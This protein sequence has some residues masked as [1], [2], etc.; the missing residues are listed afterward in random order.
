MTRTVNCAS[1]SSKSS[2]CPLSQTLSIM[3]STYKCTFCT[4]CTH[5][6]TACPIFGLTKNCTFLISGEKF[7]RLS[8]FC[9][10]CSTRYKILYDR[11]DT[12]FVCAYK[13]LNSVEIFLMYR[14]QFSSLTFAKGPFTST[15]IV[16]HPAEY[17]LV[18]QRNEKTKKS[19]QSTEKRTH[20]IPF[21]YVLFV[22]TFVRT[23]QSW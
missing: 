19:G 12:I 7:V 6:C 3:R 20:K 11:Q 5:F 10:I 23:S 14:N 21:L 17:A 15:F 4:F 13:S 2:N 1:K 22:R 8:H 18:A 9:T 16:F